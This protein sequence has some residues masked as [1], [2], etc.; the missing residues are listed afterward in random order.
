MA[1][2]QTYLRQMGALRRIAG[3]LLA[4]VFAATGIVLALIVLAIGALNIAPLRHGLLE[5]ALRLVES[6]DMRIEIGDIGG[7]WPRHLVIED[8]RLHDAEGEWLTL[9]RLA[10]D[11]Q[12]LELWR[13]RALVER[14][15]S[16]GLSVRR[17]PAG[18]SD[19]EAEGEFAIPAL[20]VEIEIEN[21]LLTETRLG[22]E[23]AGQDVAFDAEG[24]VTFARGGGALSV[25]A[26]RTDDVT[27]VLS[28][29]LAYLP[30]S[31]RGSLSLSLEDGAPGRPGIA[32]PLLDIDGLDRLALT[33]SGELR[34]G[35]MTGALSLDG[36]RTISVEIDAHGGL[37][38][39]THLEIKAAARGRLVAQELG[40]AGAPEETRAS[41]RITPLRGS[42][43]RADIASLEAGEL[44]ATGSVTATSRTGGYALQGTGEL[45]GAHHLVSPEAEALLA[46]AGWRIEGTVNDAFDAAEIAEAEVTTSAGVA[47]FTG[48][49]SFA[50]EFALTGEGSADISDLRPVGKLLGQPMAGTASLAFSDVSLE[51]DTGSFSLALESGTIATDSAELDALLAQG[52]RGNARIGF[53]GGITISATDLGIRAGNRLEA[54]GGFTLFDDGTAD[55][56]VRIGMEDAGAVAGDM[57]RGRLDA[58]AR[59]S[60]PVERPGLALNAR[61]GRGEIAGFDAR[62]AVLD[63]DLSEGRGPLS[64][65]LSGAD[66]T[67]TLRSEIELPDEGGA[68]FGAIDLNLFGARLAGAV[69][70]SSGG[71]A[72]GGLSGNRV[73]LEPLG[74]LAGLVLDG[75]A[76]IELALADNEGRQDA[77]LSLASRRIDIELTEPATLDHVT[78]EA[79]LADLT[80]SGSID[81]RLAAESGASGNS[82]F[83]RVEARAT[84][85]FDDIVISAGI[86]GER[87]TISA[88]QLSF[89]LEGRVTPSHVTLTNLDAVVGA[90]RARLGSP[91]EV[92]LRDGLT[93]LSALDLRFTGPEGAG[94][95][96]GNFA[97]RPRSAQMAFTLE[98]LPL[99]LVSSFLPFAVLGGTSSGALDLDTARETGMI[100]LRFDKAVLAEA[101]LDIR[102]AFDATL[103]AEWARRRLSLTAEALGVSETPFRLTASL[104]LIRDPAGAFPVLPE[105]GP[106]EAL[107]TWKGP[108]ASLMALADLPGQRLTGDAEIALTADGDISAPQVSGHARIANG[109]FENYETGTL[110]RDLTVNIEGRRSELL[111]FS[112]SAR[113]HADGTVNAEGTVSLA[114]DAD[115]AV[116]IRT[117][118]SNMRM[119][120]RRDLVLGVEG[121]LALTGPA[122]PPSLDAPLKLEGSLVTTEARYLI[123]QRLPGGVSTID[124]IIVHGPEEA[125]AAILADDATPLPLELDVTLRI[126]NPP[127]RVAG[128]GVDSLWSGS[129]QVTGLAEDPVVRGTLTAERGTLDFAGKTFTLAR[130]RVIFAGEQPIDPRL[131]IA[132]DYERSDFSAT[133]AVSGRGSS[134][135]IDLS[136][137]PTLPRDEIISRVLFEKG[138]GELTAFEAA[139][140]AN[141]AAELSGGGIG[142]FGV[143]N[144]IQD[145]LGLDVLRVD[146]GASGGTTLS[147]GKYLREGFYVGVE[148][149]ALASD[150]SVRVEID[151]TSN[152]SVET[153]IGNDAS[154]NVGV[155]WKWDY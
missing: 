18:D 102:P 22:E 65:R 56:E 3:G 44:A 104:P 79:E 38:R 37:S 53:G 68:R 151:V 92:E 51:G 130:G 13:G 34:E 154:S 95:L 131:D 139:Q 80:G 66:G 133:V 86:E 12:P 2:D 149:G 27:G 42:S 132:L 43:Y 119:V 123:P 145:S 75:R 109:T 99:E 41:F 150:S 148:Q 125:D 36:G 141:T 39:G 140:L 24:A 54:A 55:G 46:R 108:M 114:A 124:V 72:Q 31:G 4:L 136:S 82:R 57:A 84:G 147:A 100:S 5:Q 96:G 83:T 118:F 73:A 59:I 87:L 64:F 60:G 81:A 49:L 15:A 11:W 40:F 127:A 129:V 61:L 21:F 30:G 121:E 94:S 26:A 70:V 122:L 134:P 116:S 50:E 33:A 153:K 142:G 76:D 28:L 47:R 32:A 45:T 25:R 97:L 78:F 69:A 67:A 103:D 117:R 9:R 88:E 101:G 146:Q 35:L 17:A 120:S 23:L 20:P 106:I 6:E 62:E 115:P 29:T 105:R 110:M 126:G 52:L 155:N 19:G 63:L 14:L 58:E 7:R 77:S 137:T 85:P 107:L 16:E 143:L 1:A 112:M 98:R 152:I 8:L 48:A 71:V 135:S 111:S 10:L 113:D 144:Q 128:R 93:R 138:T 89:A 91:L 74:R 90:A